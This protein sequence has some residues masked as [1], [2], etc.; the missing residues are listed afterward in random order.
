MSMAD[1]GL[2]LLPA[3]QRELLRGMNGLTGEVPPG[4]VVDAVVALAAERGSAPAARESARELARADLLAAADRLAAALLE[5][6]VTAGQRVALC[7]EPGVDQLVGV[8]GVLRA[9]AVVLPVDP[10]A[11]HVLRWRAVERADVAVLVSQRS[12][13]D[14]LRWPER[15]DVLAVD[16][17]PQARTRATCSGRNDGHDVAFAIGEAGTALRHRDLLNL[18]ADLADRFGLGQDDRLA[19]FTPVTSGRGAQETALGLLTGMTLVFGDAAELLRPAIW[20]ALLERERVTVWHGTPSHL[21]LLVTEIE[22]R[23]ERLPERLRL[24]LVS[25]E[26]L[27]SDLVQRLRDLADSEITVVNLSSAQPDGPWVACH[28]IVGAAPV[29]PTAPI[30]RPLRNQRVHV[31]AENGGD[32]PVWVTGQVHYGGLVAEHLD[33]RDDSGATH[34]ETGEMLLRAAQYGRV[35]PDGVVEVVGDA[36]AQLVVHGRR[37][38]VHDTEVALS[39]MPEVRAAAVV[40]VADGSESLGFVRL[41]AEASAADLLD[42]LRRKVSPYLLPARIEVLDRFPLT[43]DGRVD[44][45]ALAATRAPAATR[46]ARS[47]TAP[48]GGTGAELLAAATAIA[49][50]V[51]GVDEIEPDANLLELGAT[52]VELVRLATLAEDE[53]GIEVEVEEL[54]GFPSISVL[55]GPHLSRIAEPAQPE[56]VP[57]RPRDET[58][59]LLVG[60]GR[61]QAFKDERTG[62]RHEHDRT[63][64]IGL[65]GSGDPRALA[66]R[67]ERRFSPAPVVFAD[68]A[69]L[70]GA[71]RSTDL[72]GERKF[73]Y[74]SAGDAYPLGAYLEVAPHRVQGLD[75]GIYYVHPDRAELVPVTEGG[76]VPA[77]AHADLNRAALDESAFVIHLV[78]RMNAITPLYGD[79]AWD[80]SVFEAGAMTQLL[81]SVAAE[82]G[83]G[84]CPVGTLDTSELPEPLR[85]RPHDRF[86]HAL[87]GGI[88]ARRPDGDRSGQGV[89]TWL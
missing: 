87:L 61:R 14:Q 89:G 36:S 18:A 54:L 34:Q 22:D 39:A 42:R 64:G 9:G 20:P 77:T 52:S 76:R 56:Q 5:R 45:P 85:L 57:E 48:A 29:T 10:A 17:L 82:T 50:R 37:L 69:L 12:L 70:L 58:E 6:N 81:M 80:F 51:L 86:V 23:G 15:F 65:G 72:G 83:L 30:G 40:T 25:G 67:S 71:L 88:P 60:V 11:G 66:R 13:L 79:L 47:G 46:P 8:L 53:L 19:A 7:V 33:G 3:E 75:A 1:R 16:D 26:R 84:L 63:A 28:P 62:V 32:C 41:R 44:R 35:L 68:L 73:W 31:L 24:V 27:P 38:H 4:T 21:D 78:S 49:C 55:I 59:D 2:S 43:A 74:P